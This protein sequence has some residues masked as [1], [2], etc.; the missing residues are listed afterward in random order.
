MS[1][2]YNLA[3]KSAEFTSAMTADQPDKTVIDL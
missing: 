3:K 1:E 2:K